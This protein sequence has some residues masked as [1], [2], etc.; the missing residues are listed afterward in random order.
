MEGGGERST[1][2]NPLALVEVLSDS[3]R[4]YDRGEKF[5]LY[6]SMPALRHYLLIEQSAVHVEHR[7][8]A[9]DGE[10]PTA[11]LR[12]L[13]DTLRLDALGIELPLQK[14]YERVEWA[15]ALL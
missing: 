11:V 13:K 14:V 15:S 5:L 3:T 4:D 10:W 7:W 9:A 12:S 1:L 8:Y 2:R 6:R